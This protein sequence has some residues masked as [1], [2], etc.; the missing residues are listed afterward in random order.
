M[1][2]LRATCKTMALG[3]QSSSITIGNS[4]YTLTLDVEKT[5][6]DGS[7]TLQP[8]FLSLSVTIAGRNLST[9]VSTL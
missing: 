3:S 7:G 6:A 8:N 1:E 4:T 5:D 9:K 2:I